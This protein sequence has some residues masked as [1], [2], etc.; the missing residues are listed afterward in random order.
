MMYNFVKIALDEI[1]DNINSNSHYEIKVLTILIQRIYKN[2]PLKKNSFILFNLN[3]EK[4][5]VYD[6]LEIYNNS[7]KELLI[8]NIFKNKEKSVDDIEMKD[9]INLNIDN[10]NKFKNF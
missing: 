4:N 7:Q 10:K 8:E 3:N 9:S 2:Q 5:S 1:I 6:L